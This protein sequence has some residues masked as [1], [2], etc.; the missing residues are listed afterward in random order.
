MGANALLK[1]YVNK[2]NSVNSLFKNVFQVSFNA[3]NV[4]YFKNCD[5]AKIEILS[6]NERKTEAA[7]LLEFE[8]I[9]RNLKFS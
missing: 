6:Q 5:I 3:K 1:K 8:K 7:D 4:N 2:I 9:L